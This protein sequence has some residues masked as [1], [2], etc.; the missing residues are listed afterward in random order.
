MEN[1]YS[2][3]LSPEEKNEKHEYYE[4]IHKKFDKNKSGGL[5]LDE[6]RELIGSDDE[7]PR[8]T[9]CEV[10]TA[11]DANNDGIISYE[12]MQEMVDD[13]RIKHHFQR[14]I[15]TYIQFV[16]PPRHRRR[17]RQVGAGDFGD[18]VDGRYEESYSCWPPPLA[19]VLM[20]AFEVACFITD[21]FAEKDSTLRGNG[22]TAQKFIYDPSRR[23]EAWRFLTYMFVH[24]GGS[25]Q[26][27]LGVPLEMVHTWWRVLLVYFSG[28][29]AGSLATS[30]SDP[31]IYLAGASG[32]VYAI[33]TAHIAT[34]I[35]NW[36]EMTF[37]LV[38]LMFFLLITSID[39]GTA[40]YNRYWLNLDE[41][42]GYMAHIAGALAGLLVGIWVL[43]NFIPSK[44]ETYLWWAALV[45]Y[46]VCMG[47]MIVLNIFRT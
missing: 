17:R 4:S 10:F 14:Y 7:I 11:G 12:E 45:V 20:S 6:F 21:E 35:M 2:E 18:E 15:N 43:K 46:I 8:Q 42:I 22:I 3:T 1:T 32:G 26:I 28:V 25:H 44:K 39:V 37:P 16:L 34:I 41:N 31:S 40:I 27:I 30:V 36:S 19:M 9:V 38:Q 23:H 29:L 33:I 47:V 5:D 13:N 24:I